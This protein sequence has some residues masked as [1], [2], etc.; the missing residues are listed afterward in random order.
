[1]NLNIKKQQTE[2]EVHQCLMFTPFRKFKKSEG[3]YIQGGLCNHLYLVKNGAVKI[4]RISE[5]GDELI[6]Q[7]L[8]EGEIFGEWDRLIYPD[9]IFK[10]NSFALTQ[11]TCIYRLDITSLIDQMKSRALL[12]LAPTILRQKS[13]VEKRHELL[14]KKDAS[15]RIRETLRD[16]ALRGGSKFG[17]EVLLKIWLSHEDISHLADTSRQTVTK[18]MN[19]LRNQGKIYYTRDRILFRDINNIHS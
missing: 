14:L 10:D 11:N 16:L 9:V 8:T 6:L 12:E 1:M 3:I 2:E 18:E 19:V 13:R 17:D 15:F 4:S 7:I 5:K